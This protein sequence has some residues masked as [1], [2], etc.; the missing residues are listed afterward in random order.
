MTATLCLKKCL[1]FDL[2]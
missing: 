1:T 2:L